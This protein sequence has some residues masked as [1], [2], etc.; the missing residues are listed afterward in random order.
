MSPI[1]TNA[2]VYSAWNKK[3][4]SLP[5]KPETRWEFTPWRNVPFL[6]R[7]GYENDHHLFAGSRGIV[8]PVRLH[9]RKNTKNLRSL[10]DQNHR[11]NHCKTSRFNH[12]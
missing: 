10:C 9:Q 12:R 3:K 4:R 11:A 1:H 7:F 6:I 2:S 5:E 8:G